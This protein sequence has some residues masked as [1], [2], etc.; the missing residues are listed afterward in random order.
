MTLLS[1]ADRKSQ[2]DHR[3]YAEHHNP[4]AT[5][6]TNPPPTSAQQLAHDTQGIGAEDTNARRM[7]ATITMCKSEVAQPCQAESYPHRLSC[8]RSTR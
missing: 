1:I 4:N 7:P 8:G 2:P 3:D 6:P 5:P